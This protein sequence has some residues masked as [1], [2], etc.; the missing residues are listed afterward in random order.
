MHSLTYALRQN[1]EFL[2]KSYF[3]SFEHTTIKYDLPFQL[4]F[5]ILAA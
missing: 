2:I 4:P 1:L 3:N 5:D